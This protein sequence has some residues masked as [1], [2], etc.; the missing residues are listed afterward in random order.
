[1]KRRATLVRRIGI[2]L[3]P[4]LAAT[5]TIA[6][7]SA[8]ASGANTTTDDE[9][10]DS[11][12]SATEGEFSLCRPFFG[13]GK[14]LVGDEHIPMTLT[15]EG[16]DGKLLTDTTGVTF[17]VTA[18]S[19]VVDVTDNITPITEYFGSIDPFMTQLFNKPTS[20]YYE[21][22]SAP[23]MYQLGCASQQSVS[24]VWEIRAFPEGSVLSAKRAETVIA[25]ASIGGRTPSRLSETPFLDDLEGLTPDPDLCSIG[26]DSVQVTD[27]QYCTYFTDVYNALIERTGR[28]LHPSLAYFATMFPAV[29]VY[30]FLEIG[31][32]PDWPWFLGPLGNTALATQ[33]STELSSLASNDQ[34]RAAVPAF[35]WNYCT[36]S[37]ML[38]VMPVSNAIEDDPNTP[39]DETTPPKFEITAIGRGMADALSNPRISSWPEL[40]MCISQYDFADPANPTPEEQVAQVIGFISLQITIILYFYQLFYVDIP[41]GLTKVSLTDNSDLKSIEMKSLTRIPWEWK[42]NTLASPRFGRNYSDGVSANGTPIATY[43]VTSGALPK[44]LSLNASTGAITGKAQRQGTFTFS[45]TATNSA[46]SMSHPFTMNMK[47]IRPRLSATRDDLI[48]SFTGRVSTELRGKNV[49]LQVYKYGAW[50][51]V[52]PLEVKKNGRFTA[53][54]FT[55]WVQN[56]RVVA[57]GARS[58]VVKK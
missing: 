58:L 47:R 19:T 15:I 53:E 10:D 18:G 39:E 25:T 8:N 43:S 17:E 38:A 11:I 41:M 35:T 56:Y 12:S 48:V 3:A 23:G 33:L 6:V 24:D 2:F 26:S 36:A 20:D 16:T 34:I 28:R 32:D 44:G 13:E 5:T 1:M 51:T 42:D 21:P 29:L 45:I 31:I 52:M 57:G 54:T 7:D 40:D 46:G 9:S 30:V 55:Q 49:E 27:V 14:F 37:R 4:V 22:M 50:R